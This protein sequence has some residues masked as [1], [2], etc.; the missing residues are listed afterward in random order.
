MVDGN[1]IRVLTRLLDI[2]ADTT[3]KATLERLWHEA[4]E[5][6]K[7]ERPGDLNQAL[8]EFGATVCTPRSPRCKEACPL[9]RMCHAR[10]AGSVDE[11]P[12]PPAAL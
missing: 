4:G 3:Q 8:M 2:R 1:V 7:G 9:V 12:T 5:L 10:A 11:L 6:A